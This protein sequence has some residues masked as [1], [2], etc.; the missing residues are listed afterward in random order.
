MSVSSPSGA[1]SDVAVSETGAETRIRIGSPDET[2]Q[3]RQTYVVR[4]HLAHVVNGFADHS[5]LYWNVTGERVD[6][7]TD[8]VRVTVRGPAAVT[9]AACFYGARGSTDTCTGGPGRPGHVRGP[10]PAARAS[11]SAS[12]RRSRSVRSAT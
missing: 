3:G 11:R 6:I 12:S 2:V 10:R 1:P 5:E 4:Y 9:R 8:A 7:P